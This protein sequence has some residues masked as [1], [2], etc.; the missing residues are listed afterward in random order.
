MVASYAGA[1]KMKNVTLSISAAESY[2]EA[3]KKKSLTLTEFQSL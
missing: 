1:K 2:A 3:K